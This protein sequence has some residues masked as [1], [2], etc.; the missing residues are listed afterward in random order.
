MYKKLQIL[1][2][3]EMLNIKDKWEK[4]VTINFTLKLIRMQ[5]TMKRDR[6]SSK[7]L[8]PTEKEHSMS[9]LFSVSRKHHT[10]FLLMAS[11][12]KKKASEREWG[13]RRRSAWGKRG[14]GMVGRTERE[15]ERENLLKRLLPIFF[16]FPACAFTSPILESSQSLL[17]VLKQEAGNLNKSPEQ[18]K[19]L[20]GE[21]QTGIV[22][23]VQ[24]KSTR[25]RAGSEQLTVKLQPDTG[26]L[27]A[28]GPSPWL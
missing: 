17:S 13:R 15:R 14:R 19:N 8:R 22:L 10:C 18:W 2:G 24:H 26:Y 11:T 28:Y 4:K 27:L 7:H 16:S 1:E 6:M 12:E 5:K 9:L 23:R 3:E 25:L 20:H 21:L